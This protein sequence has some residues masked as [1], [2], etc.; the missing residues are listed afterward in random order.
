MSDT[1]VPCR[2]I[3]SAKL[4]SSLRLHV[5]I[6]NLALWMI[7]YAYFGCENEIGEGEHGLVTF[8][9]EGRQTLSRLAKDIAGEN[10]HFQYFPSLDGG[11]DGEESIDGEGVSKVE[12]ARFSEFVARLVRRNINS[13]HVKDILSKAYRMGCFPADIKLKKGLGF[14]IEAVHGMTWEQFCAEEARRS[15]KRLHKV[16]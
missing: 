6:L 16:A 8:T 7:D 13:T 11:L 9:T 4:P 2:K 3:D 14:C 10:A 5:D 15:V 12:E 1:Y